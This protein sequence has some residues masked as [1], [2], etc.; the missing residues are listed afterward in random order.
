MA[1]AAV[2]P[3]YDVLPASR[4]WTKASDL[5]L[6]DLNCGEAGYEC[7]KLASSPAV[8]HARFA[9]LCRGTQVAR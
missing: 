4:R 7:A 3:G 6:D 2:G 1:L 8:A 9:R 5:L